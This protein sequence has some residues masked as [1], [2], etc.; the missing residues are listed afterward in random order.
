MDREWFILIKTI[1]SYQM[2]Q[3]YLR[4]STTL[5]EFR[6]LVAATVHIDVSEIKLVWI[7]KYLEIGTEWWSGKI[8]SEDVTM[9]HLN[10]GVRDGYPPMH[11][12]V[13]QFKKRNKK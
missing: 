3:V 4:N 13:R 2:H 10:P 7:G 1:D 5:A 12:V 6:K 11:A 9:G 8:E